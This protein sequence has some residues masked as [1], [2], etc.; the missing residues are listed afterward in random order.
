VSR[1]VIIECDRIPFEFNNVP[2]K[3]LLNW[4]IV[5]ASILFKPASPWGLPTHLQIEPT[6]FCNLK[7]ALC[8]V[9]LGLKRE[10]GN[11]DLSFFKK[12][13]DEVG[14]YIFII[15]LW[16]WGEPFI[17]PA[18]YDMISYAQN[19]NIKIVSSTN[20]HIFAKKDNAEK[21][22]KSG[23]YSLIFAIDGITQETYERYR[24]GGN[25]DTVI[26][27][28]KNIIEAK[29]ALNSKY[30][31][32]NLRFIAMKHNEHEIP[33]LKDFAES[34]GVNELTIKTLNPHDEF[35]TEEEGMKF[36]P[37]N[38][39]YR[40]FEYDPETNRRIPLKTNPCKT[41]WNLSAIHW[42]GKVSPCTYDPYDKYNIGDLTKDTFKTIWWGK[43]Y[44]QFRRQ[45]KKDYRRL[46]PCS[47]C[48]Y[49]FKGGSCIEANVE[50][51]FFSK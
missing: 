6:T 8:P 21:M 12:Y 49:A 45:F 34:L 47:F 39:A 48:T 43:A 7:C 31:F 25:L 46:E 15:L 51:C 24:K 5:E 29:R 26:E 40:R 19:K 20:G 4:M 50:S 2:L 22:V 44:K 23:L 41:L 28:I 27:G 42:D 10:T 37:D 32:V 16:D 9:T 33:K 11:M 35:N 13:I 3:K 18:I 1:K 30:P 14:D 36:I 38:H 17:N